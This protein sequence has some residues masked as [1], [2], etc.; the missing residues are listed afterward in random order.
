MRL[1]GAAIST[2]AVSASREPSPGSDK[3]WNIHSEAGEDVANLGLADL[4][5]GGHAQ[6]AVQVD[7]QLHPGKRL[8]R[9]KFSCYSFGWE[10]VNGRF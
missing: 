4:P 8:Q 6:A 1:S 3:P 10:V 5:D 7:V 9:F 2:W